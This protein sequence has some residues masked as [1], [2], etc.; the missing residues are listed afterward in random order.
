MDKSHLLKNLS[1]A[2]DEESKLSQE[3][4]D[5]EGLSSNKFRHFINNLCDFQGCNYL[6]VGS[7]KGST[8]ISASYK[9]EGIFTGIDN[10]SR[11]RSDKER[12]ISNLELFSEECKIN[13]IESDCWTVDKKSLPQDVNVYLYDGH[14]GYESQYKGIVDFYPVLAKQFILIV[15]DYSWE[16][17]KNATE[18]ALKEVKCKIDTKIEFTD[19]RNKS[20]W[21]NGVLIVLGNKS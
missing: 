21:W 3:V 6:E 7:W 14:H 20:G 8:L 16:D 4:L 10:F 17:S 12:L 11:K 13:F 1:K 18:A 2:L 19:D 9:N 15:D 5:V